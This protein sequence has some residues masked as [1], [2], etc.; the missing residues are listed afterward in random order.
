MP[1]DGS[2]FAIWR[3]NQK[4]RWMVARKTL[5]VQTLAAARVR[6]SPDDQFCRPGATARFTCFWPSADRWEGVDFE[7]LVEQVAGAAEVL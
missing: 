3:F 1:G 4:C 7:V 2:R 6:W 5:R